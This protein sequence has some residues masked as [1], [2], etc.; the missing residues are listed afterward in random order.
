MTAARQVHAASNL[1]NLGRPL[2]PAKSTIKPESM[3]LENRMTDAIIAKTGPSRR[4]LLALPV[5]RA[6]PA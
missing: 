4:R 2:W 1:E 3:T 5:A 6:R